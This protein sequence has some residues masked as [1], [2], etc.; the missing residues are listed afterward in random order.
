MAKKSGQDPNPN[1]QPSDAPI[2]ESSNAIE[3]ALEPSVNQVVEQAVE[4]ALAQVSNEQE[5]ELVRSSITT[6]M[7]ETL[8]K[9]ATQ[10]AERQIA[11]TTKAAVAP[12]S[13]KAIGDAVNTGINAAKQVQN[14]GFVEFTTGLINGTFDAI[15]GATIRQMDAYAKLVADLAKSLAQFQAEN[16]SD[17]QV[18]AQLAQRYPDGQGDTVV[19]SNYVFADT[20]ED[21]AQGITGKTA[22]QKLQE[23]VDALILETRNLKSPAKPLT[24]DDLGIADGAKQFTVEQVAKI[25]TAIAQSMATNM[26]EHLRAMAREGMARI[27]IT[28]GELSTK[29]TFNV[30]ATDVQSAQKTKYEQ[31]SVGAYI[32]AKAGW[33]PF[34]VSGGASYSSLNVNAVNESSFDAVTMSTEMIGQ[35]KLRFKTE[36]FPSITTQN[37]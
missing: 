14:L 33:G 18:N 23:V 5:R 21:T 34:S 31:D 3:S 36:T 11:R 29:L 12:K 37:P 8:S 15:I 35:V 30:T 7:R 32:N 16:I 6:V 28:D 10:S 22:S 24:S 4:G 2:A 25:R 1:Q 26:M 17:A 19:R 27:V 13:E 20:P 9:V